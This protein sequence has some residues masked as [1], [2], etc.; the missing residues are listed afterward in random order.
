MD[1]KEI[2]LKR[3]FKCSVNK[4]I[5]RIL[6][7][8]ILLHL[9][10]KIK[11]LE[12]E[13]HR[14]ELKLPECPA[15][16]TYH[17]C[18]PSEWYSSQRWTRCDTGKEGIIIQNEMMQKSN[19]TTN[20]QHWQEGPQC[21]LHYSHNWVETCPHSHPL[22]LPPFWFQNSLYTSVFLTTSS[23]ENWWSSSDL[24]EE[25]ARGSDLVPNVPS[26]RGS[27]HGLQPSP[28]S[29][30]AGEDVKE[31]AARGLPSTKIWNG[32]NALPQQ[33]C[34]HRAV[35]PSGQGQANETC[36]Q[37]KKQVSIQLTEDTLSQHP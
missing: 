32:R 37:P 28:T 18:C 6:K 3:G 21:H 36:N 2:S 13:R 10:S 33:S 5:H 25:E 11:I 14:R 1:T 9:C 22:L 15:T 17:W 30:R 8:L 7:S 24:P 23:K 19:S 4:E 27:P 29:P 20:M 16:G 26:P 34:N 31:V 12:D 35:A